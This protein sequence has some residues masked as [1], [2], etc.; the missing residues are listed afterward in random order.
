MKTANFR[1]SPDTSAKTNLPAAS[2][3]LHA[4]RLVLIH[5]LCYSAQLGT[6]SYTSQAARF[7]VPT[8]QTESR[9]QLL[10]AALLVCSFRAHSMPSHAHQS[11]RLCQLAL[12]RLHEALLSLALTAGF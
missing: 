5:S 4:Q 7:Q 6:Y 10:T 3:R 2:Y 9:Q 8:T 12:T 11:T 1:V